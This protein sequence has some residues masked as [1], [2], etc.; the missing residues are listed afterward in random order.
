MA[1]TRYSKQRETIYDVL[2][3]NPIHPSVDE[4]YSLV[5]QIIP[6]ISLGTVY[7]NLNT[8]VEQK[9]IICINTNDKAHYDARIEPHYHFICKKCGKITDIEIDEYTVKNL[10]NDVEKK[11]GNK[12][13]Y[14][15]IKMSG[16]C[17]QCMEG[18][19][20]KFNRNKNC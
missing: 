6:D 13:E 20:E 17:F 11:S 7:R 4:I 8:L 10:I 19:N 18:K 5:R 2:K 3:T 12:L 9:R 1:Q 14:L 16:V 15:D